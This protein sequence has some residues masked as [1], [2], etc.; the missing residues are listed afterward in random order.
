MGDFRFRG[1]YL[2]DHSPVEA[3]YVD[4]ILPDANRNG[5]NLGVGYAITRNLSVDVAYL[6]LLFSERQA[7]STPESQVN[8]DGTY[9]TRVNLIGVD[10]GY[11]L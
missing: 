5:I 3:A 8:F 1:G 11:N 10:L 4:P 6:L 9:H 2:Y 7:V